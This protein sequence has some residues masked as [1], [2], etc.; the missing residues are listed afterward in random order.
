MNRNTTQ[1]SVRHKVI[2]HTKL[3]HQ[4]NFKFEVDKKMLRKNFLPSSTLIDMFTYFEQLRYLDFY[5]LGKLS[6]TLPHGV[7]KLTRKF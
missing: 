5:A 7:C 4:V 3:H 2:E 1:T 6:V